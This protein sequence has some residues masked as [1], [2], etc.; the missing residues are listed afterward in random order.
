MR[1]ILGREDGEHTE[2]ISAG[3]TQGTQRRFQI[4]RT[5]SSQRKFHAGLTES[6]SP[7]SGG[8][9]RP[10]GP[11]H[12]S[13]GGART[14][15]RCDGRHSCAR[16][17]SIHAARSAAPTASQ[18]LAYA[19]EL[20]SALCGLCVKS[21]LRTLLPPLPNS[22]SS[23]RTRFL[24][25]TATD[26]PTWVL[27]VPTRPDRVPLTRAAVGVVARARARVEAGRRR[28]RPA[29]CAA[30]GAGRRPSGGGRARA[31]QGLRLRVQHGQAREAGAL[32]VLQGDAAL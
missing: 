22:A 7:L 15:G 29:A 14:N 2:A 9:C 21:S 26:Y 30:I 4:G 27:H 13:R 20:A 11:T 23:S 1:R 6:K 24:P 18:T 12:G 3:R 19:G 28:G 16:L 17:L 5:E 25:Q 10:C 8:G 31:L 32:P